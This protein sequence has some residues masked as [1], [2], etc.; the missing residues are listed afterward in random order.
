LQVDTGNWVLVLVDQNG[1]F[2]AVQNSTTSVGG[3]SA[4]VGTCWAS[5]VA[6]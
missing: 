3:L 2:K 4:V 6:A 1:S 5:F